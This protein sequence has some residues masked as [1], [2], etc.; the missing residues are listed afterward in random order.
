MHGAAKGFQNYGRECGGR[1]GRRGGRGGGK[2]SEGTDGRG[3]AHSARLA[4]PA[5]DTCH[6]STPTRVHVLTRES[7]A[8]STKESLNTSFLQHRVSRS[9]AQGVDAAAMRES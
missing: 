4:F 7:L 6:V 3:V 2:G 9:E 5:A 8:T 1:T